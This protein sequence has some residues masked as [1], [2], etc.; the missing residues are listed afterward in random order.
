M[1][2]NDSDYNYH[3]TDN[4]HNQPGDSDLIPFRVGSILREQ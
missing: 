2:D 1:G 4:C 3:Q